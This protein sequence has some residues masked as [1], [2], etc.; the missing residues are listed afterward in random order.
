MA[1]HGEEIGFGVVGLFRFF[2]GLDQLRH[3]L[4]L[5]AAGLLETAGEVVDVLRQRPQLG[6]VD[7]GQRCVVI[8]VLDRLDRIADITDRFRQAARQTAGHEEGKQ[9]GKQRQDGGLEHDFLLAPAE[10]IVGQPDD[11][12]TEVVLGGGGSGG[13]AALEKIIVQRD[14][15]EPYRCLEHLEL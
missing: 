15:L 6:V 4:M 14:T 8:A 9:Q 3:G 12:P 10:G 13:F 5:F 7:N 2:A 11:H 1:H